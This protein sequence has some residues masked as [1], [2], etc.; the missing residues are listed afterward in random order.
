MSYGSISPKDQKQP[1]TE[2]SLTIDPNDPFGEKSIFANEEF[3]KEVSLKYLYI[4]CTPTN[5]NG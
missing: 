1:S 4:I 2:I 3:W 5:N